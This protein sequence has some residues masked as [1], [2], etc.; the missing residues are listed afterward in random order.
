MQSTWP[1]TDYNDTEGI[2]KMNASFPKA[3]VAAVI[4]GV[5]ILASVVWYSLTGPAPRTSNITPADSDYP[6][7]NPHPQH[8][9]EVTLMMPASLNLQL[10][11]LYSAALGRDAHTTPVECH[12][13][14]KAGSQAKTPESHTEYSVETPVPVSL[15][16]AVNHPR[17]VGEAPYRA[18]AAVD[19]FAAGRCHWTLDRVLYRVKGAA[20]SS[21][22]LT[23][24]RDTGATRWWGAIA[25]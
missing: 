14:A 13:V 17:S 12:F 3:V 1:Q 4:V 9:I 16:D 5:I 10:S 21:Q 24:M 8:T 19:R 15:Q 22:L 7:V 18:I 23:L 11:A 2:P 20:T 6:I 25:C